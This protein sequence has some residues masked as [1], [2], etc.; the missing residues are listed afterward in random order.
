MKYP[1]KIKRKTF[2]EYRTH[3]QKVR[4]QTPVESWMPT[5]RDMQAWVGLVLHI[6]VN[7]TGSRI[8][9]KSNLWEFLDEVSEVKKA[10]LSVAGVIPWGR[11]PD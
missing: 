3:G 7:L 6:D 8:T 1:T 2:S 10:T 11:I 9:G 5:N 4:S